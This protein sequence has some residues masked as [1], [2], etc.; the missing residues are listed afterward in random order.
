MKP[1]TIGTRF[2]RPFGRSDDLVSS[3]V[4]T[5]FGASPLGSVSKTE[6]LN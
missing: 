4:I 3:L 1:F 2:R 5:G 6:D